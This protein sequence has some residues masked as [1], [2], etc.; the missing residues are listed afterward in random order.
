MLANFYR[1]PATTAYR[2]QG[3]WV[4]TWLRPVGGGI[5]SS[6]GYRSDPFTGRARMHSGVDLQASGGEPVHAAAAG[7]VIHA[8]WW[9]AYGKCVLVD[10]G[11]GRTTLYG[12]L[13]SCEVSPGTIVTRGQV[14]GLADSTGRSTGNHVHFEVRRDGRPVSPLG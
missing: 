11:S 3:T 9:G 14:I 6:F 2:Y 8:G 7:T 1:S 13:L 10:H 4:G 5:T 12:H